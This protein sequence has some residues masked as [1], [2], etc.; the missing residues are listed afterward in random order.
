MGRSVCRGLLLMMTLIAGCGPRTPTLEKT[1]PVRGSVVLANGATLPGGLITFHPQDVTRGEA[2]GII[3]TEGR[4]ELGTYKVN[5][6]VMPGAYVVTIEPIVFDGK[7]NPRPVHSLPIPFK[8]RGA[9]H[10]T[11]HVDITEEG[12]DNLTL[13]LR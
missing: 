2:R 8:Y 7:G 4:F 3:S 10:S 13:V 12:A 1:V 9:Q 6:G 5:D 11:L